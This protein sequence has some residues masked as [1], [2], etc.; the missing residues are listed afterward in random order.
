[1][2]EFCFDCGFGWLLFS[3][4]F[5][6][7]RASLLGFAEFD[8][9]S[10]DFDFDLFVW[11][12]MFDYFCYYLLV[13]SLFMFDGYWG[14]LVMVCCVWIVFFGL[15]FWFWLVCYLGFCGLRL[16]VWCSLFV[17]VLRI[18]VFKLS[19]VLWLCGRYYFVWIACV[20]DCFWLFRVVLLG[21]YW[22]MCFSDFLYLHVL[23]C[24]CLEGF[25]LGFIAWV[26][27]CWCLVV[28]FCCLIYW[29]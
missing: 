7:L 4:C 13:F 27:G 17:W 10:F 20:Y 12:L 21:V 6:C 2:L 16:F 26:L 1:M 11:L 22:L 28:S 23:V 24:L 14:A 25:L 19:L 8:I 9:C 5:I 3:G 15:G 18:D 29:C